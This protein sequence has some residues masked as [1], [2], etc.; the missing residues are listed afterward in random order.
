MT[1]ELELSTQLFK[2]LYRTMAIA[3]LEKHG[4]AIYVTG[5][6]SLS[7]PESIERFNRLGEASLA[8]MSVILKDMKAYGFDVSDTLIEQTE[9]IFEV[10]EVKKKTSKP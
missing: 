6:L 10:K 1:K 7:D 9:R 5:I 8:S 4:Q 2:D 3:T